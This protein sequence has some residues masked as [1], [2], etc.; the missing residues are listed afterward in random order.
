MLLSDKTE[1]QLFKK[2]IRKMA[3]WWRTRG[4]VLAQM[5]A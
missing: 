5:F 3:Q 1:K 2:R 4:A